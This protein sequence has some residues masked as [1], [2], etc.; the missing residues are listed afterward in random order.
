MVTK[1]TQTKIPTRIKNSLEFIKTHT[2]SLGRA[3]PCA[4]QFRAVFVVARRS[5]YLFFCF[6]FFWEKGNAIRRSKSFVGRNSLFFHA[7]HNLHHNVIQSMRIAEIPISK[8]IPFPHEIY[9]SHSTWFGVQLI[10]FLSTQWFFANGQLA[11]GMDAAH[12]HTRTQTRT[13]H[14]PFQVITQF[15]FH[16]KIFCFH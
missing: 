15:L 10:E 2:T 14:S 16:K 8:C 11:T 7:R 12:I 4:T 9:K 5:E 3:Q 6:F 13:P 1:V